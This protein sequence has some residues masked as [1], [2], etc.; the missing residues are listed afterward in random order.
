MENVNNSYFDGYY[1]DIWK[2]IIPSD[3]TVKETEFII[4]YF[5][6]APGKKVLDLMCGYGR[7]A[8]ALASK[9]IEVTAVDN[10]SDYITEIKETAVGN[11]LPIN[12][13]NSD[14]MQFTTEAK[15]DLVI[16]M[17]NS[18]N[19]F[20]PEESENLL[21][22]IY[23]LLNEKGQL[24]IHTWSIAEIAIPQ[25]KERSW[26]EINGLKYLTSSKYLFSPTRV[27][28]E[29]VMIGPKG[30]ENKIAIDYIF[31]FSEL[32]A[33]LK[34]SGFC[35]KETYSIPGK[36]TFRLGDPRAY[37]VINKETLR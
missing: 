28:T 24:F 5:N 2:S 22:K 15:F 25:F 20:S 18:F 1:K 9:G 32:A 13:I 14:V 36:K 27:E 23:S 33:L 21:Q 12:A 29:T 35:V 16:C 7:H 17:G 34:K 19:F 31:S 30:T 10:L 4:E 6:L 26:A 3:L 8:I 11:Q 37:I